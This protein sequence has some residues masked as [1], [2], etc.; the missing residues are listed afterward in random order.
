MN[1]LVLLKQ[2]PDT[3]EILR[4]EQ[5][6]AVHQ[7]MILNP[8]DEFAVEEALKLKSLGFKEVFL[9]TLGPA[10][11]KEALLT[12]LAL[13]ADKAYHLE[14]SLKDPLDV[15]KALAQKIKKL[16]DI[17][18]VLCGKLSTDMNNSAVPQM[19]AKELEFPFVTNINHLKYEQDCFTVKREG[20][21]GVEESLRVKKPCLF[22]LDKGINQPRYPTLPGIMQAKKKPYEKETLQEHE[23]R[24][25][26]PESFSLFKKERKNKILE[27][28][29][30]EQVKKLIQSLQDDEKVL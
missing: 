24:K 1:I 17:E 30:E 26:L 20:V 21:G 15:S 14:S 16:A 22:S 23:Q 3:A 6:Q 4:L 11:A 18:L 10:Q 25:T 29:L 2:V 27:G 7:K 8:Y 9:L 28:S 19:L 13:G 12:G 5:G